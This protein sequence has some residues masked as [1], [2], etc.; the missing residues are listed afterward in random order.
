MIGELNKSVDQILE[1]IDYAR[2][3]ERIESAKAKERM[4]MG[5]KGVENFPQVKTRDAVAAQLG[6]GSGKKVGKR[7]KELERL[8]GVREGSSGKRSLEP[9]N[10]VLT[11][12]DI[13]AK[14]GIS[15]DTLQNY[16]LLADMIS[17]LEEL[18]DTGISV[19]I[20]DICRM[21]VNKNEKWQQG[22]P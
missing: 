17:E 21:P 15:V 2:Q 8:Y 13:A 6:I 3:L 16:K 19:R 11:Q 4:S 1:R 12:N 5:G 7:I 9:N 18:L 14:L 22:I 10:S 20:S